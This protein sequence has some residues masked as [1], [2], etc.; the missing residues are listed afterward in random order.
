MVANRLND[1]LLGP[2]FQLLAGATPR[3]GTHG[4]RF[5]CPP[6]VD[7]QALA[8]CLTKSEA[9]Y[10]PLDQIV[11]YDITLPISSC[12]PKCNLLAIT[13]IMLKQSDK[14]ADRQSKS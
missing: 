13:S 6:L 8:Q 5:Q 14:V 12:L 3:L 2:S 9:F 1:E 4:R 7:L 11:A 10:R